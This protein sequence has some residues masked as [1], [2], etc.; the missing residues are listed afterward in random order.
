MN[1]AVVEP[2]ARGCDGQGRAERDLQ[3]DKIAS[4]GSVIFSQLPSLGV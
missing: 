1:I 3:L 4:S 2:V